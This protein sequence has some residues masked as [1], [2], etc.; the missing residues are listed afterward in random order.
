MTTVNTHHAKTHLS[1]LLEL[2][3]AGEEV[4]IARAGKPV[5]VLSRFVA[6]RP[7]IAP[8]GAMAGEG[9]MAEDFDA[10]IDDMFDALREDHAPAAPSEP[11]RRARTRRSPRR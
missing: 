1:R 7:A 3:E 11:A 8:P 9:A 5:A 2:V 10:P 4:I 6:K